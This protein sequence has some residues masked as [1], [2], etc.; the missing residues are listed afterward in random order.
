MFGTGFILVA[1]RHA[2]DVI[3]LRGANIGSLEP[4][5]C[6]GAWLPLPLSIGVYLAAQMYIW[7][8]RYFVE[9]IHKIYCDDFVYT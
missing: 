3:S 9:I 4:C 5:L 6:E 1:L 7:N 8:S 2:S